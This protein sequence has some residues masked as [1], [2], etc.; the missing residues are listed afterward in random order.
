[1][2]F[3]ED[4]ELTIDYSNYVVFKQ[5][6]VTAVQKVGA[7]VDFSAL[8]IGNEYTIS[9]TARVAVVD[10]D[11]I[12]RDADYAIDLLSRTKLGDM[13]KAFAETVSQAYDKMKE[14]LDA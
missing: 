8:G 5:F 11:G 3:D 1:M 2:L 9:A 13:V 6:E 12:I 7:P 14:I 4:L 10:H